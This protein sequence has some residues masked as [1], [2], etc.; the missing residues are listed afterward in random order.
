MWSGLGVLFVAV[1][2]A[3]G[4]GSSSK[5]SGSSTASTT[6]QDVVIAP[7]GPPQT[8]GTLTY[9]LASESDGWNPTQGRWAT[10]GTQV[11]MAI[12]DP[13]AAYNADGD[14]APY[15]AESFTPNA[16]F[17]EW[18]IKLRPDV[19]FQ[20]GTPFTAAA[21][22]KTLNAHRQS[23][24]TKP[25]FANVD[26]LEA[27][28]PLTV[29]VKMNAPWAAFPVALTGQ[30]GVM[31]APEQLDDPNGSSNPIGTG[32]FTFVSWTPDKDLVLKRNPNY[33]QKDANGQ[34]L[35]YLDGVRFVPIP[36]DG[37]RTASIQTG[38]IDMTHT[39]EIG[40]IDTFRSMAASGQL[41]MVEQRGAA[42]VTFAQFNMLEPP[43]D[44]IRAREAAVH[45]IDQQKW[46]DVATQG[47]NQAATSVFRPSSKWYYDADYPS[48]DLEEA[49]RLVGEYEADKGPLEFSYSTLSTPVA[50]QQGELI[51]SMLEE[52]G[53]K[54]TVKSTEA[55]SFIVDGALGQYQMIQWGQFGSPDPD[56]EHVW[57]YSANAS[58]VGQLALNFPRNKDPLVDEALNKARS[59][60]DFETRK[61]AY[62]DLQ[63][64]F[65]ADVPYAFLDYPT[66]V[67]VAQNKVRGMLQDTLP[68]G[69]ASI[70]MGGPGSFSLV[71]RLTQTWLAQ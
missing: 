62:I 20:N 9:G 21:V 36:D 16:D 23:A 22:V 28:D 27:T 8:G 17:T 68:D 2:L 55:S 7:D 38:D 71:T 15:L 60:D 44:D 18:T 1:L 45:A 26:S 25:T 64:R 34:Q 4:C 10:D 40:S 41:Q 13:L 39:T 47:E 43:F 37:A 51:K 70:P 58:P 59:T 19:T 67:K 63:K 14:W 12:F 29:T 5:D 50:T 3:S 54:V 56:Y 31:P 53:M 69:E 46:I 48:Y 57:W 30:A 6:P 49:K 61:Q 32:P 52:A 33:W 65:A 66:P 11:G 24:L 42:E 35:P